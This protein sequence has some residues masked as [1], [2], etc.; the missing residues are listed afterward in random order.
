MPSDSDT[1]GTIAD[2]HTS[3][4]SSASNGQ[5]SRATLVDSATHAAEAETP[6]PEAEPLGRQGIFHALRYRDF[7]LMW[8]GS[9]F[10]SAG[11][12]I[13]QATLGWVVYSMTGSG[14]ILGAING[15]R[16]VPML[17]LSPV[18]GVAADRMNRKMLMV[19]T[20]IF[21]TVI[22]FALAIDIAL[23]SLEVWHLFVFTFFAGA[24]WSFNMP[25]RQSV[26]F[27]LVPRS[28]FPNAFALNSVAFNVTRILGPSSAGFLIL[29]LGPEGNFFIQGIAYLL[30]SISLLM[31]VIPASSARGEVRKTSVATSMKEGFRYVFK[32]PV[33]R[34]LMVMGLFPVFFVFP[35]MGLLPIFA[36]DVYHGGPQAFG[37]LLSVS[38][39]GGVLGGLF[40]AKLGNGFERR[41]L[42]QIVTMFL[43]GI[44]VLIFSLTGAL[45]AGCILLVFTGFSQMV[46]M[47]TNQTLLQTNI[48]DE[49]R[50][51]V[52]SIYM[53]DQG[54]MPLG[55]VIAGVGSDLF[56]VQSVVFVMGL[57][58]ALLAVVVA[59]WVPR[60]RNMR[61]D[62][63][64]V[65]V[66]YGGR[67]GGGR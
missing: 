6:K 16:S 54:L 57:T 53:L 27:N 61:L 38:G 49:L 13:Q 37:I 4:V 60:V 36:K 40:A 9:F 33:V 14:S 5:T 22:T 65:P 25:V 20:Q 62:A 39:V 45:W 41:G 32:E 2:E 51:R 44:G 21:L 46:F 31:I 24:A 66:R 34:T 42:L 11:Q 18:A 35:Y 59:L 52:T 47:T 23:G 55:T 17:F 58:C 63:S 43:F 3:P 19:G 64:A 15:M 50:G 29:W 48:P 12:W 1:V 8:I 10:S 67:G 26:V 7:R 56:G 28:V 30:V